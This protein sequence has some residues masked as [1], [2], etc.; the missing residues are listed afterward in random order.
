MHT[1]V[2][3]FLAD[4]IQALDATILVPV[5]PTL[6]V[7]LHGSSADAFWTGTSYLL[8]HSVLQPSIASLS[9]IFGRRELLIPSLLCF[10]AGSV[11][12]GVAHD[13]KAMLLGRVIQG[14]GG[15][16][17]ISLSQ[18]C[19][20]DIVPLRFRPKWFTM[21]LGA[22]AVGTVIGPLVGGT[23]VEKATWRWCFF[24]NLPICGVALPMCYFLGSLS[25]P[26]TDLMSKL[27]QIDW[28][29]NFLFIASLTGLL[30]GISWA[31]IQ[32][33]WASYQTILPLVLGGLGLIGSLYYEW[34]WSKVPF[35]TKELFK[36]RSA[37]ASYFAA[38]FQG[39]SLYMCMYYLAFY[40][41][42]AKQFPPIRTGLSLIPST[43][44]M[45][46]ASSI[47]NALITRFGSYRP[48]IW[49]GFTVG[50]LGGG[51]FAMFND[52]TK[53]PVWA[54]CQCIYGAG[55]GMV[56]SAV[57]VSI[58]AAV[59]PEH[60][61]RA[62]GMYAFMRSI[63]MALGVAIGGTV[64][65]NVMKAELVK[66]GVPHAAEIAKNSEAYVEVLK[67]MSTVGQEGML[68]AGVML[69][70]VHG[71]RGIFITM[72]AM[73]A[74]GGIISGLIKKGSLDKKLQS[75]FRVA[76]FVMS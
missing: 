11:A 59:D 41:T 31:G 74:V 10:A 65:Q 16:G 55:M 20:A 66:L 68:R 51:L 37:L 40:F 76:T 22:W 23:L 29:G 28:L 1:I 75:K 27:R 42:A 46:P 71:F 36:G 62:A 32:Y 48:Y 6:A 17:I 18:V 63:G 50:T 9:D 43:A 8:T 35:L 39:L 2:A 64:F 25:Q 57:N 54:V 4:Q 21:V 24:L 58:Q 67:H 47:T 3:D 14:I 44:L 33:A 60:A 49:V 61:G 34:C 70:Y 73:C 12:C 38:M 30:V 45:L 53:T 19:F 26:K 69:G 72:T 52:Q 13:F 7:E 5:L 15:A 56:L